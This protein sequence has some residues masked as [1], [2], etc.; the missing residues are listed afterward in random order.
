MENNQVGHPKGMTY[1]MP[2]FSASLA[3]LARFP[4]PAAGLLIALLLV[5]GRSTGQAGPDS[6]APV[7]RH[8]QP[9]P[10]ALPEVRVALGERGTVHLPPQATHRR[11]GT[12]DSERGELRLAGGLLVGYDIG[13]MAGTHVSAYNRGGDRFPEGNPTPFSAYHER[14]L[15]PLQA[16]LGLRPSLAGLNAVATLQ[17]AGRPLD[18]AAA[19][20]PANFWALVHT[21]TELEQFLALVFSYRPVAKP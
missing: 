5:P 3:R 9:L 2:L 19:A 14:T 7:L 18:D 13:P 8:Y 1:I 17:A 12:K 11:T 20:F 6:L 21:Q 15:G 16:T 10:L 4:L